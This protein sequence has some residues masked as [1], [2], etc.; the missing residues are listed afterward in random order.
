MRIAGGLALL[1][2]GFALMSGSFSKKSDYEESSQAV[3]KDTSDISF[4]PM[5][6]P[7]LSGPGAISYLITMYNQ[8]PGFVERA[9]IIGAIVACTM[10]VYLS[11]RLA[12]FLVRVLGPSGLNAIARIMG[13][14]VIAIGVQFI[15]DGMVHLIPEIK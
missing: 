10:L 1:L 11:L 7:M 12:P 8:H 15:V 14:L 4:A 13:F 9:S 3:G 6:M 2:N 5:A